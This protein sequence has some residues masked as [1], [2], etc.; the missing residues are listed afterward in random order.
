MS[1]ELNSGCL[2]ALMVYGFGI[3]QFAG[4]VAICVFILKGCGVI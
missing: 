2:T 3:L 4:A 1:K